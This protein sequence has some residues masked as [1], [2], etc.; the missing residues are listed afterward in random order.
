VNDV[1]AQHYG[2]PNVY[3]SH[4]RRVALPDDRRNGL[5]GQASVLL[6][7]SYGNRTSPV[8]RGKWLLE[9]I[10]GTPPPPPPPNVPTL[11]ER[12]SDGKPQTMR[13]R[14]NAHRQNPVCATCHNLMDPLGF[15]L[16]NFDAV[17]AWRVTDETGKPIDASGS[18]VDGTKLDGPTALRSHLL[19]HSDS[20]VH[21]F[22][23][24]LLTYALGRGLESTDQP[25][26]R[27]ILRE[28]APQEYRWSAI[29]AGIVRSAPF[30]MRKVSRDPAQA[31]PAVARRE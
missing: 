2:I 19:R 18:L 29:V 17:G 22:T 21:T 14:L 25:T 4:F 28:A 6:A 13:E 7:T 23:E 3:G 27:R 31:A 1:L 8:L 12:G 11:Q 16:E 30:Q 5:L 9:N 20:F 24:K 10:L 15:A 26:I